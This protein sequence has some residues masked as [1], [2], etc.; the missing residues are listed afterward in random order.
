[1]FAS[2]KKWN[3]ALN[4]SLITFNSKSMSAKSLPE[5]RLTNRIFP[6]ANKA[7]IERKN[8]LGKIG[9]PKKFLSKNTELIEKLFEDASRLYTY[10]QNPENKEKLAP[11]LTSEHASTDAGKVF[12]F[13]REMISGE[14]GG[15]IE[16]ILA[17]NGF[18]AILLRE[19]MLSL[20]EKLR[21]AGNYS[22]TVFLS[23]SKGSGKSLSLNYLGMFALEHNWLWINF[24]FAEKI[25][26]Y[27]GQ[28]MRAKEREETFYQVEVAR[29][30]FRDILHTQAEKL[31]TENLKKE[32]KSNFVPE[33]K[34]ESES[35]NKDEEKSET[36]LSPEDYEKMVEQQ[37]KSLKAEIS[38]DK[39]RQKA[40][41]KL[42]EN[43]KEHLSL[44]RETGFNGGA[45]NSLYDMASF[46]AGNSCVNPAELLYDFLE[47]ISQCEKFFESSK[48]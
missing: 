26:N 46:G 47:E 45:S 16:K 32:Y 11:I 20:S 25:S 38:E 15:K 37:E 31:K 21:S 48:V 12:L 7:L 13:N 14:F 30:F 9:F 8:L 42:K 35:Q 33:E 3:R 36:E 5:T 18:P 40:A 23:G 29:T 1:M 39:E 27:S 4:N 10:T 19:H 41:E 34:E 2:Q 44:D 43:I 28:I 17:R 22:K 24:P 6:I